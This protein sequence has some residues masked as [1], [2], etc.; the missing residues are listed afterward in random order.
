LKAINNKNKYVRS[1]QHILSGNPSA[2]QTLQTEDAKEYVG[3]PS[4][5]AFP[6]DAIYSQLK[7]NNNMSNQ[8]KYENLKSSF[9]LNTPSISRNGKIIS[10]LRQRNDDKE[11][12][13][14][15]SVE[16]SEN[17]KLKKSIQQAMECTKP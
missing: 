17:E 2:T 12:R 11:F 3:T 16:E 14:S 8:P 15:S 5:S 1:I 4:N 6:L 13:E 10:S 7:S 9:T